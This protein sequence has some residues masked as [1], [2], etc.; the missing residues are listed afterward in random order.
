MQTNK[1]NYLLAVFVS[2]LVV[3]LDQ[4]TKYFVNQTFALHSQTEIVSNFLN[5]VHIR[6]PGVAFGLLKHFGSNFKLI[7]LLIVTA[8]A[9]FLIVYLITEIR[10]DDKLQTFGLSLILG[11]AIGNLIDRFWLGEVIDFID[12]HWRSL[13][14]W[15]AFNVADSAITV[16]IG[17]IVLNEFLKWKKLKQKLDKAEKNNS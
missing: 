16:G 7:S 15:P 8:V 3:G 9:L 1:K 4:L 10:K 6:N 2:S 14:H 17:I 11:G 13:Y 12:V 5:I